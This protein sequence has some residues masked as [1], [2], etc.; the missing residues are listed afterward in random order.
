MNGDFYYGD[1]IS[2]KIEGSGI[3]ISSQ[4][5]YTYTG[6]FVKNKFDGKGK[7]NYEENDIYDIYTSYEGNFS[8]GYMHGEGNL[9]FSDDSNYD[10]I[11]I[12]I[13]LK[14]MEYCILRMV[15]NIMVIGKKIIW[16]E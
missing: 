5:K 15:E 3:Y 14:E 8:E 2:G 16:M 12:K 6:E 10:V 7:I 9:I 1:F 13:V 11:L 4:N